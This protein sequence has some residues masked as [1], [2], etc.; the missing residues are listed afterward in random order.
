MRVANIDTSEARAVDIMMEEHDFANINTFTNALGRI[1]QFKDIKVGNIV[2]YWMNAFGPG[3]VFGL[4]Y[5]PAFSA[6]MTNTYVGAYLDQQMTI[7]KVAGQ[8]MVKFVK[9]ILQIGA[10][11]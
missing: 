7:E 11:V 9:T 6:M 5:F 3:T 2:S 8:S 10:S 1:I 4:E